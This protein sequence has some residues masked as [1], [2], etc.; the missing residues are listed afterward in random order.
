MDENTPLAIQWAEGVFFVLGWIVMEEDGPRRP[1]LQQQQICGTD[2]AVLRAAPPRGWWQK[3][4]LGRALEAMVAAGVRCT[5]VQ[6]AAEEWLRRYGMQRAREAP[7]RRALLPQL[8]DRVEAD[9]GLDLRNGTVL[10]SAPA[11]DRETGEILLQLGRRV[12]YV[13]VAAGTGQGELEALLLHR[14]GLGQGRPDRAALEICLGE[15]RRGGAPAL[16]LGQDCARQQ[17]LQT[18]VNGEEWPETVPAALFQAGKVEKGAI[19]LKSVE[20]RP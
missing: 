4:R 5:A 14:L 1:Q 17:R 20:F 15:V 19:C 2:F 3:R 11:A 16:Y 13:A 6:G 7:L 8:L 9:W 12:R 18:I 10:L